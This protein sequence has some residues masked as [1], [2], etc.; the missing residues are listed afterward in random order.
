MPEIGIYH[1]QKPGNARFLIMMSL[2]NM[3][4][5]QN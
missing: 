4:S 2:Q 3:I 1:N 5:D